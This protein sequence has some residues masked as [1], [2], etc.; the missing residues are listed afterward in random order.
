MWSRK[1][2]ELLYQAGDQMMSVKYM[3]KDN[4]FV[5]EKPRVWAAKLGGAT[6]F[7]LSP[8]GKRLAVVTPVETPEPRKPEHEVTMVFNFFD[9]LRRR[10]P[11]GK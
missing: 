11:V 2:R 4:V 9:E 3:V 8:D 10:A 6:D 5:A 7:D 1:D